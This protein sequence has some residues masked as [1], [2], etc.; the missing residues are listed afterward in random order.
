MRL[1]RGEL[2]DGDTIV[3]DVSS[4]DQLVFERARAAAAA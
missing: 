3:V 4:S 1:L 2:R